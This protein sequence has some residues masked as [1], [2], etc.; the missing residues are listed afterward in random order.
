[1]NVEVMQAMSEVT[2]EASSYL[3][4]RQESLYFLVHQHVLLLPTYVAKMVLP[5]WVVYGLGK[6]HL[7]AFAECVS[8]LSAPT[9]D[10]CFGH[11]L[12]QVCLHFTWC[13]T[14]G[15]ELFLFLSQLFFFSS[16]MSLKVLAEACPS[17]ILCSEMMPPLH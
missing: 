10:S 16:F 15:K 13:V 4:T 11:L 7:Q 12:Y 3:P 14:L 6:P 9:L 17:C 8:H 1:M 5:E 2:K